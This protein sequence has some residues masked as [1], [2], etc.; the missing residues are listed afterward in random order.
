VPRQDRFGPHDGGDLRQGLAPE[1]LADLSQRPA[2]AVGQLQLAMNLRPEN[3]VLRDEIFVS[4]EELI[5][6]RARN[7]RQHGLPV[8]RRS[9]YC[10]WSENIRQY[11]RPRLVDPG[12]AGD[13]ETA[14]RQH[15]RIT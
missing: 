4:P 7:E 2:F 6:D 3:A 11:P 5:V 9:R 13:P 12:L 15:I 1:L 14:L 8:H 10:A